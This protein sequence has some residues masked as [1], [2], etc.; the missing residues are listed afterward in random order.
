MTRI[1]GG[2]Q[3]AGKLYSLP[4]LN[5]SPKIYR[6]PAKNSS[7][8]AKQAATQQS[9]PRQQ[10]PTVNQPNFSLELPY[11]EIQKIAEQS[12]FVGLTER[13]IQR[14]YLRGD[15]LLVDTQA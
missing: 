11:L 1:E 15:S 3:G 12:G 7:Q 5:N 4:E 14:A 13:D 2:A 10:L 8:V 6:H 9:S